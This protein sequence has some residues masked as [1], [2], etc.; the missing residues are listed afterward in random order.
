MTTGPVGY[1]FEHRFQLY[2]LP[3]R[4]QQQPHIKTKVLQSP[5]L[6]KKSDNR[7]A[8]V[9]EIC[10]LAVKKADSMKSTSPKNRKHKQNILSCWTGHDPSRQD[11]A[12]FRVNHQLNLQYYCFLLVSF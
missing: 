3:N 1:V 4:P 2:W 10:Q 6:P 11:R 9:L 7:L 5:N 8:G 12:G